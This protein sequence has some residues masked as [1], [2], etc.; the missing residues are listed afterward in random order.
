MSQMFTF[1]TPEVQSEVKL[2][3]RRGEKFSCRSNQE[4]QK[5]FIREHI[6]VFIGRGMNT[7]TWTHTGT[8]TH[9]HQAAA[10]ETCWSPGLQWHWS[11]RPLIGWV[12]LQLL[13]VAARRTYSPTCA[14]DDEEEVKD[15]EEESGRLVQSCFS[16]VK[17]TDCSCTNEFI[18]NTVW[19]FSSAGERRERKV[20]VF[21]FSFNFLFLL[22]NVFISTLFVMVF[23]LHFA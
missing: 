18:I 10:S 12:V 19:S 23:T 8:H 9:T 14:E 15:E 3:C 11:V 22:I 13:L 16:I 21:T 4:E 5:S 7:H 1:T 20:T 17:E 6:C 2:F